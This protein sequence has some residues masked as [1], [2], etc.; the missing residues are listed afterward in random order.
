[1]LSVHDPPSGARHRPLLQVMPEAQGMD[2]LQAL[3]S[4]P[5]QT[6]PWQV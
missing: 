3:S 5:A 1:L 2:A 4:S 6:P